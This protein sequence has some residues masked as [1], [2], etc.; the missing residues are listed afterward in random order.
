MIPIEGI[1][2]IIALIVGGLM[3]ATV[4]YGIYMII[5]TICKKKED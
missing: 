3:A 5:D 2:D 1:N 4:A